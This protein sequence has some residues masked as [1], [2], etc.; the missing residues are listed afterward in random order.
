[1][2]NGVTHFGALVDDEDPTKPRS[3]APYPSAWGYGL[4]SLIAGTIGIGLLV[5]YVYKVS[6]LP[7]GVQNRVFFI[8]L[9]I[10]ALSC[11]IALFGILRSKAHITYK[12]L[13][14]VVELGGAAALFALILYFGQKETGKLPEPFDLTVRVRSADEPMI[15]SGKV[16]IDLD[17]D[18][19]TEAIGGNGEV[20]F[21]RIPP[22]FER[23]A[24]KI[25]PQVA[26]YEEKWQPY[27]I[28]GSVIEISLVKAHHETLLRGTVE[29]LPA[30]KT[31]TVKA[32]GQDGEA[33]VD[34]YGEFKLLVNGKDGDR[35]RV[36]VFSDGKLVYDDYQ[37]LPG[38]ATLKPQKLR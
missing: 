13:G 27:Q 19:R 10:S 15:T 18:R 23:A 7:P 20:N 2:R 5:F 21:K 36:R 3:D 14:I 37:V 38:P 22:D 34:K 31:I 8:I 25:L 30:G 16:T 17:S 9:L 29:P 26:G 12:H 4:M 24:I 1:M 32:E 33:Q 6:S 11:S 28:T 35:V